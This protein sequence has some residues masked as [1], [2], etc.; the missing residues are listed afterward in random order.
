MDTNYTRFFLYILS[1][2]FYRKQNKILHNYRFLHN[3]LLSNVHQNINFIFLYYIILFIYLFFGTGGR[4]GIYWKAN[5]RV[6][7]YWFIPPLW[8]LR[9]RDRNLTEPSHWTLL[10]PVY[11]INKFYLFSESTIQNSRPFWY[12]ISLPFPIPL[13]FVFFLFDRCG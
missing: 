5:R 4:A 2:H 7:D 11:T 10:C 6:F 12:C 8:T 1:F 3:I 9:S 13:L